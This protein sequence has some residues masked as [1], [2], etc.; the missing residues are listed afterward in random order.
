MLVLEHNSSVPLD[1]PIQ[2]EV[3]HATLVY[4]ISAADLNHKWPITPSVCVPLSKRYVVNE[5]VT[6]WVKRIGCIRMHVGGVGMELG[7]M[8]LFAHCHW[9]VLLLFWSGF[10]AFSALLCQCCVDWV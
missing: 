9:E 1:T 6:M 2:S 5:V 3:Q 7:H 8:Q 4:F 10:L